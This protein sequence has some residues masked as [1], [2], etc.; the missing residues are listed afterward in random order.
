MHTDLVVREHA[1]H[2]I[3]YGGMDHRV[4]RLIRHNRKTGWFDLTPLG[5]QRREDLRR[6]MA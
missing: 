1:G 4:P 3:N 6:E 5:R 2:R